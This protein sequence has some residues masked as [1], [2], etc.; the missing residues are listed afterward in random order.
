MLCLCSSDFVAL[1]SSAIM[2]KTLL[3]HAVPTYFCPG[4]GR[5]TTAWGSLQVEQPMGRCTV[6]EIIP[7]LHCIFTELSPSCFGLS[8]LEILEES[9]AE[10]SKEVLP[11]SLSFRPLPFNILGQNLH[12]T[13][14]WQHIFFDHC[15]LILKCLCK[16]VQEMILTLNNLI[17]VQQEG[18][19][20]GYFLKQF[21]IRT[22][23]W[24]QR[25]LSS[26]CMLSL[27]SLTQKNRETQS[28]WEGSTSDFG[29]IYLEFTWGRSSYSGCLL[30]TSR[31][32]AC[33]SVK[34][35][36]SAL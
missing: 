16:F 32:P 31:S 11:G 13:G 27:Y 36:A 33:R 24:H 10:A 23:K 26:V 14:G 4:F 15:H 18:S 25:S 1:K 2:N 3:A 7:C 22:D 28:L 6:G 20:V 21:N 19:N 8:Q 5:S 35:P 30:C 17:L 29:G 12:C 34:S 9:L